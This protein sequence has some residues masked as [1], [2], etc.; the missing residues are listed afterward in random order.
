MFYVL[1]LDIKYTKMSP[2]DKKLYQDYL[3]TKAQQNYARSD[4]IRQILANKGIM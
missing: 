1:G 3:D 4:E 2:E